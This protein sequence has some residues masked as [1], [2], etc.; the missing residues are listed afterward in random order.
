MSILMAF[1]WRYFQ[2]VLNLWQSPFNW[3]GR[4]E[5]VHV[6][7]SE[8]RE[9]VRDVYLQIHWRWI[10]AQLFAFYNYN[11][12]HKNNPKCLAVYNIN[13]QVSG[14]QAPRYL[15]C[16]KHLLPE[17]PAKKLLKQDITLWFNESFIFSFFQRKEETENILSLRGG[18]TNLFSGKSF[19][20]NI[21]ID[22]SHCRYMLRNHEE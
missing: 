15:R 12:Y 7:I 16:S 1:E 19:F 22:I 3:A 6:R 14:H 21:G 8:F 11:I 17:I 9:H 2:T 4:G 10:F 13:T 18:K 5:R 20:K